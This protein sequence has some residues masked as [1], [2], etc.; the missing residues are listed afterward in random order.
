MGSHLS[1]SSPCPQENENILSNTN[2][3]SH[4]NRGKLL[5]KRLK[6]RNND[7]THDTSKYLFQDTLEQF[8][9]KAHLFI[10]GCSGQYAPALSYKSHPCDVL[11]NRFN[12]EHVLLRHLRRAG[13]ETFYAALM[14]L[15]RTLHR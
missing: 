2:F 11:K 13:L 8:M 4:A 3:T 10:N 1:D 12:D 7:Y 14:I 6:P 5:T 15:T 9:I